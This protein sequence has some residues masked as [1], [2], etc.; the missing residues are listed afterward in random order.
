M[1]NPS[2]TLLLP[3]PKCPVCTPGQTSGSQDGLR[4]RQRTAQRLRELLAAEKSEAPEEEVVRKSSSTVME[5][6][7][8]LG[9]EAEGTV[10]DSEELRVLWHGGEGLRE[11]GG[12]ARREGF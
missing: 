9:E 11:G 4:Y 12:E 6:V 10:M 3:L 2:A 8:W 5:Q 7:R 1:S